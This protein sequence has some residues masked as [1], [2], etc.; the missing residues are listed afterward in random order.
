MY[1]SPSVTKAIMLASGDQLRLRI[2][3]GN[4]W[5]E[6]TGASRVCNDQFAQIIAGNE[7]DVHDALPVRGPSNLANSL[8][9]L[10]STDLARSYVHNEAFVAIGCVARDRKYTICN[11]HS[12]AR[13]AKPRNI[14]RIGLRVCGLSSWDGL[15]DA[16][17]QC[18][19]TQFP[20]AATWLG[21]VSYIDYELIAIM[22]PGR[23]FPCCE[24]R[25][26]S[27]RWVKQPDAIQTRCYHEL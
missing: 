20:F 27:I 15:L 13:Q 18:Y 6:E 3:A 2:S 7:A 25:V 21:K 24:R 1:T 14:F 5:F 19:D 22:C 17:I 11:L 26:C 4:F 12:I 9:R 23:S 10:K 16:A 8:A